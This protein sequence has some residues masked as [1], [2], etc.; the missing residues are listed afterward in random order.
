VR[1]GER[2][3]LPIDLEEEIIQSA[4]STLFVNKDE[5][6]P[7]A[8]GRWVSLRTRVTEDQYVLALVSD[9]TAMKEAELSLK[10]FADRMKDL[11][12]TDALTGLANR[13]AFDDRLKR[14]FD[15]ARQT[16]RPLSVIMVDVDRF[17]TYNDR[18]GH[19]AGDDCLKSVAGAI[20]AAARRSRD[21]TARF[22][23]EEFAVLLPDTDSDTAI[24]IAEKIRVA[25]RELGMPNESSEYGIV[26]VSLG[27]AVFMRDFR[28]GNPAELVARADMALYQAKDAGRDRVGFL[29][30]NDDHARKP[31][32]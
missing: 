31:A 23:G 16:Y 5:I 9:I 7:L 4:G 25:I 26:T 13:R 20:A 22:G 30:S 10:S 18:Y 15:A 29:R 12:E 24:A 28:L 11:A 27:A 1:N 32:C 21:I 19:L 2:K 14:E 8:D 6:I 17:K 3:D